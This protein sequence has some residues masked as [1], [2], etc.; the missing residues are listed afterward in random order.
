MEDFLEYNKDEWSEVRI[1]IINYYFRV[2]WVV[3]RFDG[4][5]NSVVRFE[6]ENTDTKEVTKYEKYDS[7]ITAFR[8]YVDRKKA[9][10]DW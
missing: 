2:L 3:T 8:L 9:T 4:F 5:G 10:G 7:A 1:S 6:L